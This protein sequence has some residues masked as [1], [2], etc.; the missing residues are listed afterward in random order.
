MKQ[1]ICGYRISSASHKSLSRLA[2]DD[3]TIETSNTLINGPISLRK[4]EESI[5]F[6]QTS[7][8]INTNYSKILT[9]TKNQE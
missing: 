8:K 2:Y 4:I 6:T 5:L 9:Q 7:C 1:I 3:V